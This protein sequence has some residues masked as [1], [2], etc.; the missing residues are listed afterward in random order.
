MWQEQGG[1]LPCA[2]SGLRS[3]S[4]GNAHQEAAT[5]ACSRAG[6]GPRAGCSGGRAVQS[7]GPCVCANL[8][9]DGLHSGRGVLLQ[10]PGLVRSC[11]GG[12]CRSCTWRRRERGRLRGHLLPCGG[13]P[14]RRDGPGEPGCSRS[15]GGCPVC[16]V[17]PP[18]LPGA[19]LR[20]SVSREETLHAP[21]PPLW[22]QK[23]FVRLYPGALG[24]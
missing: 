24:R 5:R 3:H 10:S 6:T 16:S 2:G 21:R 12:G 18:A 7:G 19:R 13:F 23:W 1:C 11:F 22:N 20:H 4:P 17:Q 9:H 8:F 15:G 14:G